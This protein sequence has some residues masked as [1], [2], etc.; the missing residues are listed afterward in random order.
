MGVSTD[1]LAAGRGVRQPGGRD[2]PGNDSGRSTTPE[3]PPDRSASAV[4][5]ATA[6]LQFLDPDVTGSCRERTTTGR[7]AGK[8][9]KHQPAHRRSPSTLHEQR[10]PAREVLR[11]DELQ[12]RSLHVTVTPGRESTRALPVRGLGR[13]GLHG[14]VRGG[15]CL[16]LGVLASHHWSLPAG[17]A[18]AGAMYAG[19]FVGARAVLTRICRSRHQVAQE[20]AR[21]L[22]G[23]VVREEQPAGRLSAAG[24][25]RQPS[26]EPAGTFVQ[27]SA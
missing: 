23:L 25:T 5:L 26:E 17:L 2:R 3:T 19:A 1:L 14:V 21:R 4:P 11:V 7:E 13:R 9:R 27:R 22:E 24:E 12:S 16:S 20:V 18:W 6:A 10:Q 8:V 15:L